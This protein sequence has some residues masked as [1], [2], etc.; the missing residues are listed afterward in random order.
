MGQAII[1]LGKYKPAVAK[2]NLTEQWFYP[3]DKNKYWFLRLYFVQTAYNKYTRVLCQMNSNYDTIWYLYMHLLDYICL[4][5]KYC[6][7]IVILGKEVLLR[8]YSPMQS[9]IHVKSVYLLILTVLLKCNAQPH[10]QAL[11]CLKHLF[12][13]FP[14][15]WFLLW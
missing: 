1:E 4:L 2:A 12:V 10:G 8:R 3:Q 14:R 6:L 9:V 5:N 7:A 13:P 15:Q 11:H